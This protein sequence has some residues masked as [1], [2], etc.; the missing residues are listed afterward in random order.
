M[1]RASD[2]ARERLGMDPTRARALVRL[3]RSIAGRVALERAYRSGALSWV[4]ASTLAPLATEDDPPL[5]EEWVAWAGK[6][7]V[8]RLRDDVEEALT[9]AETDP[10]PSAAARDSRP[11][12]IGKSVRR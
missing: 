7:T 1:P 12:P 11:K 2:Y 5:L 6:V 8:R 9:L 4:K 10:R 3:E